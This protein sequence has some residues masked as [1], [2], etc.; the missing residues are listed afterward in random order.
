MFLKKSPI[1]K[2]ISAWKAVIVVSAICATIVFLVFLFL[3][4]LEYRADGQV[5]ISNQG[6]Y[7]VDPYT[8]AKSAER[9]AETIVHIIHTDDFYNRFVDVAKFTSFSHFDIEYLESL[10][11][12]A[13]RKLWENTVDASV[14]YGSGILNIMLYH[15]DKE[16]VNELAGVVLDTL[17]KNGS[18]YMGENV[19]MRIVNQPIVSKLPV[20]PNIFFATIGAF[21]IGIIGAAG[22]VILAKK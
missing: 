6:V 22:V 17:V 18:E 21:L 20:R 13:K 10:D 9:N 5:L 3:I 4:P 19:Q 16:V 12:R 1:Q 15:K 2:V 8:A 11:S 7:G 14:E